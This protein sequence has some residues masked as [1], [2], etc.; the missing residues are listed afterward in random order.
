MKDPYEVLGTPKTASQAEIRRAYRRLA[1]ELHPDLH[2][3]EKDYEARF[4]D[5][6][7]AYE[8]LSDPEKRRRFDAG[9]IDAS[10]MER[11]ERRF[12]KA[13][14][15]GDEGEKY[16]RGFAF[17]EGANMEDIINELFGGAR[18][19][20][21]P[22]IRMPGADVSYTMRV[23]FLDAARGARRRLTLPDGRTIN[24]DIPA[25]IADRQSLRL[26]GQGQPGF[27]GGPP[28]DAFIEVHIE[29]HP[30]FTRKDMDVHV[31][32]PVTLREAVLGG[33]IE[34][35]T[36]DG[37]VALTIPENSNT[38]TVLRLKGRGIR[39]RKSG[40][41][42]DQYVKLKVVLPEKSDEKLKEF[43]H[44]WTP[45]PAEDVRRKAGMS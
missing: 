5:V 32:V 8:L 37:S 45:K 33:R 10:G 26:K 14:A 19:G 2:P 7:A 28:G 24:V 4:K 1:K 16:S 15:G 31:E 34:V 43:L 40:V 3:G 21:R 41:R 38:G 36:I 39:D 35:P 44:H 6:A 25:G 13:Y 27:G 18:P 42:G 9:E 23:S 11:P 12:Y 17:R 29:P 20:R 22:R 30:F